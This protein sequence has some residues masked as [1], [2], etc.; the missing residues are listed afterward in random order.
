MKKEGDLHDLKP[1]RERREYY[2]FEFPFPVLGEMTITEVNNRKVDL[3]ATE[4]LIKDIS[5]GGVKVQ[6]TLKLPINADI[7][8]LDSIL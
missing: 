5:L 6:S 3:G 2:R 1:E 4:I 8:D 7:Q